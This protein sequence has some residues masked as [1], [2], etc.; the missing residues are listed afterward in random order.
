MKGRKILIGIL[1]IVLLLAAAF[2]YFNYRNRTLSPPGNETLT[3]G[4]ITVSVSYS[5]PSVRGRVIFGSED[6]NAL[7]PY[8]KYWRLGA[9]EATEVTFNRD[10]LFNGSPVKAGTYTMYAIPG[11]ESF[12]V[13]LNSETDRWGA[14]EPDYDLDVLHTKVPVEKI[15]APVEQYTISLAPAGDGINMIFEWSDVRFVVPLKVQ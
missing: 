15:S 13:A 8:G 5:R 1:A 4:G 2:F 9:N 12:E 14:R 10:I 11:P 6:Q 7:Q 3:S